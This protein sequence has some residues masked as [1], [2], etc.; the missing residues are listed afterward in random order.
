[1]MTDINIEMYLA[2]LNQQRYQFWTWLEK[3]N[4][5]I[6]AISDNWVPDQYLDALL[7]MYLKI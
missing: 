7:Y 1:M 2:P 5:L 3:K 4:L 6:G